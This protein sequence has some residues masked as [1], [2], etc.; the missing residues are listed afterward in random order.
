VRY[1]QIS[2]SYSY[3]GRFPPN[4]AVHS[5]F[6]LRVWHGVEFVV[7]LAKGISSMT[8]GVGYLFNV[9]VDHSLFGRR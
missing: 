8:M 9:G 1:T 3:Y 4:D 5:D 7:K 2:T 6:L